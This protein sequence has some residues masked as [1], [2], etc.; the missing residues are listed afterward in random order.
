MPK[1]NFFSPMAIK[2]WPFDTKKLGNAIK[3]SEIVPVKVN[4]SQKWLSW[5]LPWFSSIQVIPVISC[6]KLHKWSALLVTFLSW[7]STFR[8]KKILNAS[9]A[10]DNSLLCFLFYL[11]NFYDR[12]LG[13][14]TITF[15]LFQ[16]L[17]QFWRNYILLFYFC[18][19]VPEK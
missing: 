19:M 15:A 4:V 14:D 12:D 1:F 10:D 8:I 18:E 17:W 13:P 3:M 2:K 7:P 11:W 9:T 5:T 6:S 16:Q